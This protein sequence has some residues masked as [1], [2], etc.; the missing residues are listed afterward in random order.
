[1][2]VCTDSL[3]SIP[4]FLAAHAGNGQIGALVATKVRT[5][6][7]GAIEYFRSR[8]LGMLAEDVAIYKT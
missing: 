6:I 8:I 7:T 3:T 5:V 4:A 2:Q 1:M